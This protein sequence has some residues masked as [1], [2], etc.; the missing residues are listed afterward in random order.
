MARS[1]YERQGFPDQGQV[2]MNTE[3]QT[4]RNHVSFCHFS[5]NRIFWDLK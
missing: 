3:K 1:L 2:R 4:I 5:K